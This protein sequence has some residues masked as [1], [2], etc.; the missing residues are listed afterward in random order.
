M[1]PNTIMIDQKDNVAIALT[2]IPEGSQVFLPDG[3]N[4]ISLT[5]IPY[6]HKVLLANLGA[7]D[8]VIKYGEVIGQVNAD[9]QQGEWIHTHNLVVTEG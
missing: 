9:L 4:F 2:D 6:S 1:I 5:D 7:G 3:R 8:N